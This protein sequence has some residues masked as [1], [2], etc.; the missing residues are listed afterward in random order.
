MNFVMA[1]WVSLLCSV[2]DY[3]EKIVEGLT[4]TIRHDYRVVEA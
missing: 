1:S 2:L 4:A 3:G